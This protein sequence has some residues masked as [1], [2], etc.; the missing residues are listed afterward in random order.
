MFCDL[1]GCVAAVLCGIILILW[2]FLRERRCTSDYTDEE[3][4]AYWQL[5]DAVARERHKAGFIMFAVG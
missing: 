2:N 3:C 5:E 1:T 4:E